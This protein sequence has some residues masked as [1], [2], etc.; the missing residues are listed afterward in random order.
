LISFGSNKKGVLS[1][2]EINSLKNDNIP[3]LQL[4]FQPE[5]DYALELPQEPLFSLIGF[6]ISLCRSTMRLCLIQQQIQDICF[7]AEFD[8]P[9][10]K[11]LLFVKNLINEKMS[12]IKEE[13]HMSNRRIDEMSTSQ[14]EL[15]S[16]QEDNSKKI[17]QEIKN[18]NK[19][20]TTKPIK[21]IICLKII[22]TVLKD[23]KLEIH[24]PSIKKRLSNWNTFIR[25]DGK[26]GAAPLAGYEY[27]RLQT[28]SFF[29]DWVLTTFLPD[30]RA[31][32]RKKGDALNDAIHGLF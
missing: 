13:I 14:I 32:L 1:K 3:L 22:E 8:L 26:K 7:E 21:S 11:E 12:E 16:K 20:E 19:A 23:A 28:P 31:R 17:Q 30:Y 5:S 18:R 2:K 4:V 27:A 24:F 9:T 15:N 6:F 10:R 29:K 25:T